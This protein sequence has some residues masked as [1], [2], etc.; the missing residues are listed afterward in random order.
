MSLNRVCLTG[1]L[2]AA[3]ELRQ[4][5]SGMAVLTFRIAVN[6]RR[7]NNKTG[8]WDDYTN[9]IGIS[10]FGTRAQSVAQYLHKGSK[11]GID[12]H[13]RYS[14]WERD[15]QRRSN[16]E[17]IAD[18]IE[19]LSPKQQASQGQYVQA[20]VYDEPQQGAFDDGIPF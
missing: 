13:L 8:N 10:M 4:T 11:V 16:V 17:V 6:E 15:G 5:A 19:L 12:G 20:E 9:W 2:G 7:K 3:P 1:N 18:D 14:E